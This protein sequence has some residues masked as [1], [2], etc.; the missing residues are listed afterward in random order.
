MSAPEHDA[1]P[2]IDVAPLVAGPPASAR[3]AS[4]ALRAREA[5][6]DACERTGFAT[7]R[8]HG[9]PAPVVARMR[10]AAE[11]FFALP[12]ERKHLAA[13]RRWND[14]SRNVYRGW[15]PSAVAGKEG[16][17]LGDPR[18][19]ASDRDLLAR[20]WYELPA[21]PDELDGDWHRA[22]ADYFGAVSALGVALVR[23]L[24]AALGGDAALA[25]SAFARPR[26]LSTLRLNL[27]PAGLAPV[28]TSADDGAPLACETHVDSG[29]LTLLHQDEV[30]GLEVRDG[31]GR[32]RSVPFAADTFVVNTGRALERMSGGRLRATAHRVRATG[33][34]RLS[35]PLFL[36]P[37]HDVA[38]APA[39]LGLAPRDGDGRDAETYEDFL[40]AQMAAFAEY[41]R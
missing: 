32:W 33:R 2:C 13:P 11:R 40:R 18:L 26:S 24:A 35:I 28:E 34:R 37:A 10:A 3:D 8:G 22:V 1:I 5:L 7:V 29:V 15:F 31:A 21:L 38:V 20:P 36:E 19:A 4:P 16:L 30:G 25:A 17:D 6:R 9:V 12:P 27:Y 14:Q 39:A 23:A 41:E